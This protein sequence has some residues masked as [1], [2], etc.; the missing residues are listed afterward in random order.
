MNEEP[1]RECVIEYF[2]QCIKFDNN[3]SMSIEVLEKAIEYIQ[4]VPKYRKKAKRWKRKYMS[5]RSKVERI[6]AEIAED[7][8]NA[9]KEAK[10]TQDDVDFGKGIGLHFA[11]DAVNKY[12]AEGR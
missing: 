5:L 2:R 7:L 8:A 9:E 11:L 12:T 3:F 1:T 4:Q 6:R 10:Q